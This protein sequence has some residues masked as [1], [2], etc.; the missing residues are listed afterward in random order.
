MYFIRNEKSLITKWRTRVNAVLA[1]R[2]M[3]NSPCLNNFWNI[4]KFYFS[5]LSR[6]ENPRPKKLI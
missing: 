2:N 6:L 1:S 4:T 3:E 5:D